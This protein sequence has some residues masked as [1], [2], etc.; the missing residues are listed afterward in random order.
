MP[1]P[2]LIDPLSTLLNNYEDQ[3]FITEGFKTGF[4]LEYEGPD[5]PVFAENSSSV[6]KNPEIAAEKIAS[7]LNLSRFAG[8]FEQEPFNNFKISPLAVRAKKEVGKYRVLHNLS[9]PYNEDAVNFNIPESSSKVQYEKL[10]DAIK[11]IQKY[12]GAWLAKTDIA[13]AFRLIPLHPSQYKLTGFQFEGKFYYDRCLPMGCSS[14]C[15][16]F[17]RF[18][19]ALKWILT[20]HYNVQDV[21]KVLDD[22]LFIAPTFDK[23]Q[24]N[25][26]AF[27]NMCQNIG[28]PIAHH[29]TEGPSCCLTFLGIELDTKNMVARLPLEKLTDY[30]K[31]VDNLLTSSSCTLRTLKT[32][33]GQLQFSTS[34]VTSGRPFLRRM[35][36]ATIGIKKPY[37][38][39]KITNNI[40]R[41]LQIW[42]TFLSFYNGVS[43][44]HKPETK[45]SSE[46]HLFSDSSKLGFGGV[47]GNHF[48]HG[49]FPLT[50]QKLDIQVL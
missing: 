5:T 42:N 46:L 25:L 31:N 48:I 37:H 18:S 27:M 8:P 21:V 14:S 44:I 23:C 10:S 33:I 16:I 26:D 32:M 43:I 24:N 7:E 12:D 3:K 2:I 9:F 17:E 22:F 1:T 29:K 30:N 20:N 49:K 40:K 39:I 45:T 19:S 50:W 47:F 34:V 13:E 35:Y 11:I 28:V 38:Y 41:D 15:L 36:D 6:T 4:N